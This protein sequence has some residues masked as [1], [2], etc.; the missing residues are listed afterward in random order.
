ML[1]ATPE[2]ATESARPS[3]SRVGTVEKIGDWGRIC[4]GVR[5]DALLE[6]ED[7]S[8]EGASVCGRAVAIGRVSGFNGASCFDEILPDAATFECS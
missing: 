7:L 3:S 6:R 1:M 5:E 8:L 4:F 2:L